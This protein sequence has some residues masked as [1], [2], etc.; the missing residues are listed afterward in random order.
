[1]TAA[2]AV[3]DAG[4]P[5]AAAVVKDPLDLRIVANYS[6]CRDSP[7]QV[8]DQRVGQRAN[9]ASCVAPAIVE[10]GRTLTNTARVDRHGNRRHVHVHGIEAAADSCTLSKHW[11]GVERVGL[12]R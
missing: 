12:S 3:T 7:G 11:Q 5:V 2:V 4:D 10:A 6:A 1:M 9:G 8:G